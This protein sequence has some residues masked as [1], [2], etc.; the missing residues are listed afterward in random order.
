MN[1][2]NQKIAAGAVLFALAGSSAA[3]ADIAVN[4]NGQPLT[5]SVSPMQVG[6]RTLV[7]M[8]DIFEALGAQLSWNPVAQ[9]IT[10]Q[11]DLTK[12][13]LA[14]DNPNALVNGRNVVLEQP[15]TL[16]NGRT[17]VPLRFVA[18]ATGAQVDWNGA[19]QLISIRG[20]GAAPANASIPV[21]TNPGTP[22]GGTQVAN[23]R[24]I[25][26]PEDAV[27]PV[28]IDQALTS[29]TARVG[30]TFT[31]SIISR[32]LGD[33]EFPAGTKIEGR[34][35]E[36]RPSQ[37]NQPGVLDIEWFGA[38]TPDGDRVPLQGDLTSLDTSNV[39][40][41]GGRIVANGAKKNDKLKVIG[42]G[43]GAGFVL[44]RVLGTNSTVTTILGAAGGYLFG[45]SRDKRAQEATIATG[46]TL[47]VRLNDDVRYA[48]TSDYFAYRSQFLRASDPNAGRF[49][50]NYYGFDETAAIPSDT[51]GNNNP[52]RYAGYDYS[53]RL[54]QPSLG[55][56][57]NIGDIYPEDVQGRGLNQDNRPIDNR[58]ID[59]R[60]FD[61]R[62]IDNRPVDNRFPDVQI[63]DN[64]QVA[65]LQQISIPEGAVVPVTLDQGLTSATAKVGQQFTA[66][67]ISERLGDSEF[68]AGSKLQGRVI[69]SRPQQGDEPGTLDL[70]FRNAVLPD[71]TTI[72]LRG[73]LVSLDDKSVQTQNGRI[74]AK[75]GGKNNDR[76]K[77]IGIGA[78][79][80]FVVGR[81]VKKD[82]ILPSLLGALGGYLYSNKKGDKPAEAKVP[83]GARLGVRLDDD[84]RYSDTTDYYGYRNRYLRQS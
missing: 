65:G 55:N 3:H 59:N 83:Q 18:E 54:P 13:Q 26:I 80:G 78:A 50:P 38:V 66:T 9:T 35:I 2:K 27:I 70:E 19:L 43:A 8:R 84:V 31:A 30:Q 12:I 10:A 67:I 24:T 1:T 37:N 41:T 16:V 20:N 21:N 57:G 45:K 56:P 74:V 77:V 34:V 46:T 40:M 28:Q 68:P 15:A 82:G 76:L 11:K 17:F 53:D 63:P 71:G 62:P 48:D 69:E 23:A 32:R 51:R 79:A 72:P 52:N 33:S 58:P 6:G 42:I 5:T 49:D 7:P 36:A 39:Q 47:G 73:E 64:R 22:L 81:V 29:A 44:G 4:L 25:A 75:A 61:N 14:I 60:P